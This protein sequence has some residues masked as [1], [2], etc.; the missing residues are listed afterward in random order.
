MAGDNPSTIRPRVGRTMP[1]DKILGR[2]P[3]R[4]IAPEDNTDIMSQAITGTNTSSI[5]SIPKRRARVAAE[6]NAFL[7]KGA[8]ASGTMT[9]RQTGARALAIRHFEELA[10]GAR[11][12]ENYQRRKRSI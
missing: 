4:G 11:D 5:P 10:K 7:K 8:Q 12:I 6:E 1:R 9:A 3:N 2:G